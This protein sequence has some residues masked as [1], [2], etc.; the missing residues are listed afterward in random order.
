MALN[1]VINNIYRYP[2]T[3]KLICEKENPKLEQF[4]ENFVQEKMKRFTTNKELIAF[5]E[6][7]PK[8]SFSKAKA[9]F[10]RQHRK[11]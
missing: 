11:Y 3:F 10:D 6:K 9:I 2:I 7:H 5:L 4:L 8:Y 1:T